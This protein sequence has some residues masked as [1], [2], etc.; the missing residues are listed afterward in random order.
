M[1]P[2][3]ALFLALGA[4]S[5]AQFA[6]MHTNG[7]LVSPTNLTIPQ[8]S[9]SGLSSALDSKL[10]TNP[11]LAISNTAGLQSALDG[12]LATNGTL[13]VSNVSGLQSALDGKLATNGSAA[14]LTNFPG[15]LLRHGTNG[16][17]SYTNTNPLT[18]TNPLLLSGGA[19]N[20]QPQLLWETDDGIGNGGI[21]VQGRR[22]A[23]NL[24]NSPTNAHTNWSVMYIGQNL[25]TNYS[26]GATLKNTNM[27]AAFFTIENEYNW[28][29]NPADPVTE[30]YFDVIAQGGTSRSR[31]LGVVTS[32][33]N[34]NDGLIALTHA[35]YIQPAG[36]QL[37]NSGFAT[38]PALSVVQDNPSS[39]SPHVEIKN[40]ST[41]NTDTRIYINQNNTIGVLMM[42]NSGMQLWRNVEPFRAFI[43]S[44]NG[45][46]IGAASG[47]EIAS[48]VHLGGNTRIDGA[49]TFDNTTNAATTRT[50]LG[51]GSGITTNVSSGTLQFS[52][53]ILIGHTP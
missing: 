34:A 48:R 33:T 50:N 31:P 11:T 12:K 17:V 18:F 28:D 8:S 53:G 37:R 5:Y 26:G 30:M 2:I 22:F 20:N 47:T 52:N 6:V 13:A 42:N 25:M 43:T 23:T 4:T 14:A 21:F 10:G 7:V 36:K 19:T 29:G 49:I 27:G 41:N 32:Q 40:P 9:V 24:W 35:T 1:K 3:L 45:V 39:G 51:L 15:N 16:Q 44:T 38:L 46:I